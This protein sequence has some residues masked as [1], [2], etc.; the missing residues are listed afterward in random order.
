[1]E[2]EEQM[3]RSVTSIFQLYTYIF[4]IFKSKKKNVH[5][6][7]SVFKSLESQYYIKKYLKASKKNNVHIQLMYSLKLYF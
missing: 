6:I 3:R 2:I 5:L 4:N 1:M 7:I